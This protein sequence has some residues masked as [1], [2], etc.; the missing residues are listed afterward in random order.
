MTSGGTNASTQSCETDRNVCPTEDGDKGQ[1]DKNV[2]PTGSWFSELVQGAIGEAADAQVDGLLD[3]AVAQAY[4]E[5][6]VVE[7]LVE[8]IGGPGSGDGVA[9]GDAPTAVVEADEVEGRF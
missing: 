9:A 3:V 1:A 5:G 8:L 6:E 2:C 7:A 4:L